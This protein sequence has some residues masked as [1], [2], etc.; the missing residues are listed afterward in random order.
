MFKKTQYLMAMLLTLAAVGAAG[1]GPAS[2]KIIHDFT[3]TAKSVIITGEQTG[4]ITYHFGS[5]TTLTCLTNR[6]NGTSSLP[7]SRLTLEFT[8]SSCLING[9]T[10]A[11][12]D[13]E[14]CR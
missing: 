14:N 9:M 8:H 3:S 5:G 12:V 10:T 7:T 4:P 6:V 2:A 13:S 1:A 11:T